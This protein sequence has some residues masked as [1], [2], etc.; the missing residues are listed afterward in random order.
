MRPRLICKFGH[1]LCNSTLYNLG[2]QKELDLNAS[3]RMTRYLKSIKQTLV[4]FIQ[5]CVIFHSRI[6][7]A[8]SGIISRYTRMFIVRQV[9][10]FPK[11][12]DLF[13]KIHLNIV[14]GLVYWGC[15][16]YEYFMVSAIHLIYSD[17]V[18]HFGYFIQNLERKPL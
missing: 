18:S 15:Q 3:M 7:W 6:V 9:L 17:R 5:T 8:E 1:R 11:T 4:F 12:N 2:Y 13:G 14:D 10:A 16:C